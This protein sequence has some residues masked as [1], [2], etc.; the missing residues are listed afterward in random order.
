M[1]ITPDK[2]EKSVRFPGVH[3]KEAAPRSRSELQ[4]GVPVFVGFGVVSPQPPIYQDDCKFSAI[5]RFKELRLTSW[6]QFEQCI[7]ADGCEGYLD[8]AVRGFFENGGQNCAVVP[9]DAAAVGN[10]LTNALENLFRVHG[11]LEDIENIDLVCVPDLMRREILGSSSTVAVLQQHMLDYCRRMGDRFAVLDGLPY[12]RAAEH[13]VNGTTGVNSRNIVGFF[14]DHVRKI[15]NKGRPTEGAMYAPWIRVQPMARH[16]GNNCIWV[17]PCGH[18]AGIYAR[19]DR[20]LGVHKAPANEIVEG[21]IDLGF[22]VSDKEQAELNDFGLN[23]LRSFPG[24]GIRV[25]GSR[26]LS[27]RAE[28]KYINIRRLILTLVRWSR[29]NLN[30]IVFEPNEPALWNRLKKRIGAYC[31]GLYKRGA[32]KGRRPADAFFVKCDAETNPPDI[33]EAGQVICEIGLAPVV[34]AEFVVVRIVKQNSGMTTI[35]PT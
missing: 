4:T 19:S 2:I 35:L 14:L 24:R 8:Y 22:H 12:G 1:E 10:A 11:P 15:S 6:S 16:N 33:R 23:C 32:L 9:L 29:L 21:A 13:H 25:W 5:G 26:T 17:P 34:P 28:W 30:D 27:S 3:I 18:M 20:A 7:P 31:F